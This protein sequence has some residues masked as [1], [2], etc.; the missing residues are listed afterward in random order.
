MTTLNTDPAFREPLA[1]ATWRDRAK[2]SVES[3]ERAT[4]DESECV[5]EGAEQTDFL[6]EGRL[7]DTRAL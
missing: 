5:A 6:V 4:A 2:S 7:S 1:T 3:G